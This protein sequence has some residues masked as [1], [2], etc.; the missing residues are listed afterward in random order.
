MDVTFVRFHLEAR[1]LCIQLRH[2]KYSLDG[3]HLVKQLLTVFSDYWDTFDTFSGRYKIDL[4]ISKRLYI[5][6]TI[7]IV[8]QQLCHG[9]NRLADSVSLLSLGPDRWP[10]RES[11]HLPS[12]VSRGSS[13][14]QTIL[15]AGRLQVASQSRWPHE[16][17]G[18]ILAE[19]VRASKATGEMGVAMPADFVDSEADVIALPDPA[20]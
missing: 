1:W 20:C 15:S 4:F 7:I 3:G 9:S 10:S 13:D 14:F 18:V 11:T 16:A 6:Q 8:F 2:L 5:S 12:P 19:R 17:C